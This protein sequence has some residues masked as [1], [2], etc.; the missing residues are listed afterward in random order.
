[1]ATLEDAIA[2]I[3]R[4][5]PYRDETSNA[6]VTKML[7]LADWHNLIQGKQ[8]VTNVQWYFDNYGPFVWDVRNAVAQSRVMSIET[9]QNYYGT[10]KDQFVL[11]DAAYEPDLSADEK[12]ALDHV[13]TETKAL[14]WPAF[15]K[16]VYSTYPVATSERYTRLN[17]VAKAK[18]Y[19]RLE[20]R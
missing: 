12:A 15:I 18:E 19:R 3:L 9:T 6:R 5:Y 7:Y 8:S 14:T 1:M 13:I 20:A 10:P 11:T 16:L 2:Y 17:L 4:E